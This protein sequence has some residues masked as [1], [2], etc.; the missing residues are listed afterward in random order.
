MPAAT[1]A[2]LSALAATSS[3]SAAAFLLVV[4]VVV[5]AQENYRPEEKQAGMLG[6][7]GTEAGEKSTGAVSTVFPP[8][9]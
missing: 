5:V 9:E 4:V 7:G 1:P 3:L 8:A 2:A 6:R